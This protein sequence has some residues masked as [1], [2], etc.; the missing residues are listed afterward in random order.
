MVKGLV[1]QTNETATGRLA[2]NQV[3]AIAA[4]SIWQGRGIHATSRPMPTAPE[5]ERRFRCHSAGLPSRGA[6]GRNALCARNVSW[7]G[8]QRLNCRLDIFSLAL[9]RQ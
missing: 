3:A 7:E 9:C 5:A 1:S 8:S 4:I 2:R 6:S